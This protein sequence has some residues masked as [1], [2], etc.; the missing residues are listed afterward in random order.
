MSTVHTVHAKVPL[1]FDLTIDSYLGYTS[2]PSNLSQELKQTFWHPQPLDKPFSF[3]SFNT[4]ISR[5]KKNIL[6][7]ELGYHP[8][9]PPSNSLWLILIV[10]L[11]GIGHRGHRETKPT[12]QV[13]KGRGACCLEGRQSRPDLLCGGPRGARG[14]GC[15]VWRWPTRG[16]VGD[17]LETG[18]GS[19]RARG[20]GRCTPPPGPTRAQDPPGE[21]LRRI[22]VTIKALQCNSIHLVVFSY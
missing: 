4:E 15:R 16:G 18:V 1:L 17:T 19:S 14:G 3:I 13:S 20:R 5:E 10:V 8:S 22:G 11:V 12:N 9:I 6:G 7:S 2:H 21:F